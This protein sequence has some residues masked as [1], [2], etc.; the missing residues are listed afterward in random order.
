MQQKYYN[1]AN[2]TFASA[3]MSK[4]EDD[5]MTLLPAEFNPG[6]WDVICQRGKEC[7]EHGKRRTSSA[8]VGNRRFRTIIEQHLDTYMEVMSRSQKTKI[9]STIVRDIR[10]RASQSGG[11]F[12][13]KD[14][15]TRRW[16][17][18]SDKLA[19]EKVGQA[20]RDAIK[21]RRSKGNKKGR[22]SEGMTGGTFKGVRNTM[23]EDEQVVQFPLSRMPTP[24]PME[25]VS[26][27]PSNVPL[28]NSGRKRG[29]GTVGYSQQLVADLEPTP[30]RAQESFSTP[31]FFN[32]SSV[33]H[34]RSQTSASTLL[35]L[36]EESKNDA[37]AAFANQSR[38]VSLSQMSFH[39]IS[40]GMTL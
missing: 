1:I 39:P 26:D 16:L 38:R 33:A 22:K 8:S 20:L 29:V 4:A 32:R 31:V 10:A 13:R 30:I 11:G 7:F 9:V 23:R 5:T 21:I 3:A 34:Q 28:F 27:S 14:L 6:K 19:R 40:G 24:T 35:R 18:V 37:A 17:K 36:L 12:V 25:V 2:S 15:L